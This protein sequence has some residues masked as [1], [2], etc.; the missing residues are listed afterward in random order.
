PIFGGHRGAFVAQNIERD[1]V[2][3]GGDQ[4]AVGDEAGGAVRVGVEHPDLVAH[5][6]R[7]GN[8]KAAELAAAEH[9][10]G[11][12]RE[13]HDA[14]LNPGSCRALPRSGGPGTRRAS[15]P[16]RHPRW[17]AARPRTGRRW[18]RPPRRWRRWRPGCPWASAR[19]RAANPA[20][21]APS[22]AP[23]RRAPAG[24]SWPRPCPAGGPRPL[25]R[26]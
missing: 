9:A 18:P 17:R 14:R 22:T 4:V 1:V 2:V 12:R 7:G 8:E 21:T 25:R 15:A 6:V 5:L 24:W 20:P 16:A 19:S 10:E 11:G 3:V 26:R 23:A 13:D